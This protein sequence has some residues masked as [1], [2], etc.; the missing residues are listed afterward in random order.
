MMSNVEKQSEAQIEPALT[1]P[2]VAN[3]TTPIAQIEEE[4]LVGS[5]NG[6]GSTLLDEGETTIAVAQEPRSITG[7][8]PIVVP[9]RASRLD[10]R[11]VR[12]IED[13]PRG[14]RW[15]RRLPEVCR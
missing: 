3:D 9:R 10:R 2:N 7:D 14:E 1:A 6:Q 15:K 8:T 13:L 12:R 4:E 11:W 5:G